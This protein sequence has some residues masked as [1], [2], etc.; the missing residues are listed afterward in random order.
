MNPYY[1]VH[2]CSIL[3]CCITSYIILQLVNWPKHGIRFVLVLLANSIVLG[4]LSLLYYPYLKIGL[5]VVDALI[6]NVYVQKEKKKI[7]PIIG[8]VLL[9][10]ACEFIGYPVFLFMAQYVNRIQYVN[11]WTNAIVLLIPQFVVFSIY[12]LYQRIHSEEKGACRSFEFIFQII[13]LPIFTFINIIVMMM[14]SA[15]YMDPLMLSFILLDMIFVVFLNIYI[16]YLFEKMKENVR[17]KQQAIQ[18]EEMGKMQYTYYQKL[19]EKYRQSRSLIH[20]MKRHLQVLESKDIPQQ[21][22]EVY[23]GELQQLFDNYTHEVYSNHPIVNIILH[24]KYEE[25]KAKGI[26]V[27]YQIAPVDFHFMRD[28]DV[29]I[30][31]ANLLDNAIDACSE[32]EHPYFTFRIDQ[33]Q[34]FIVMVLTNSSKPKVNIKKSSKAGHE[35]LG[36]KN[37][38]QTL[39]SYG[40]NIQVASKGHEF[41]V[42]LYI[43]IV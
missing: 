30:V 43:P 25:A 17:L 8:I 7:V 6:L 37:V 34:D 27:T 21:H 18:L 39:E 35:G 3:A 2:I 1:F 20:D 42:H 31:F 10:G 11:V 29:T 16:F 19:E 26:Q 13:V 23:Q 4:L 41:I 32:I 33:I 36:L 22:R 24:E 40:G 12:W 28:M 14:L 38:T 5:M 15:Y 9:L